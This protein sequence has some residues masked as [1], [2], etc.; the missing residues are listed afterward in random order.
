MRLFIFGLAILVGMLGCAVQGEEVDYKEYLIEMQGVTVTR[1]ELVRFPQ[2]QIFFES[3]DRFVTL[4]GRAEFSPGR[5]EVVRRDLET[6]Y[7]GAPVELARTWFTSTEAARF[8]EFSELNNQDSVINLSPM[9][10]R[11]HV[12][13]LAIP[14]EDRRALIYVDLHA[15]F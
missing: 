4:V 1:L 8:E 11:K 5:W 2:K 6:G 10:K 7:F 14:T 3:P 13:A 12:R 9:M 15:P